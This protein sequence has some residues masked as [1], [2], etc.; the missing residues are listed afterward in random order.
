MYFP[1]FCKVMVATCVVFTMILFSPVVFLISAV[2]IGGVPVAEQDSLL[3]LYARITEAG[4]TT[5]GGTTERKTKSSTNKSSEKHYSAS[6]STGR[7]CQR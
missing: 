7:K 6:G 5:L 3:S 1:S 2:Y 4:D